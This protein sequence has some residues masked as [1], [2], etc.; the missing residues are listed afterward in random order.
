M[1]A[2]ND[3]IPLADAVFPLTGE[4]GSAFAIIGKVRRAILRSNHPELAKQF[5][6][7]AI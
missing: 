7:V 4:D 2:N 3:E 5:V 6:A 1:N